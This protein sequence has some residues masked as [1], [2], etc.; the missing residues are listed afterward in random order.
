MLQLNSFRQLCYDSL[1]LSSTLIWFQPKC[2]AYLSSYIF[3]PSAAN[4]PQTRYA[5][6]AL[7]V[8]MGGNKGPKHGTKG[9]NQHHHH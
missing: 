7:D 2:T 9:E 3:P 6:H 5:I 8:T 4:T 1:S